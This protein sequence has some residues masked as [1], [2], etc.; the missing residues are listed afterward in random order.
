MRFPRTVT[1]FIVSVAFLVSV[2]AVV[3]DTQPVMAGNKSCTGWESRRTP[4]RKIR[5]LITQTGQVDKVS[6]RSYVKRV[7][8][9]GEWPSWM[10]FQALKAGAFATMQ[11][12]W[13]YS[14]KGHWRGGISRGRC[15]DVVNT[16]SDQLYRPGASPTRKQAHA[17]REIWGYSLWKWG[18]RF[19]LTGYRSGSSSIC[20]AD[21]NGWKLYA[22][23]MNNCARKLDW[24]W[25]RILKRYFVKSTFKRSPALIA[26]ST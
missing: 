15:Y 6:F 8:A 1:I 19:F 13:Y 7:M 3:S 4:P 11:Y 22:T 2:T 14:L 21:V 26:A 25:K 9:S 24:R 18:S 12:A 16:T 23:S 10:H 17:V 5:V 20:A